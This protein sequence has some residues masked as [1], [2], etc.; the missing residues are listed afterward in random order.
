MIN[1]SDCGQKNDSKQI[2]YYWTNFFREYNYNPKFVFLMLL[3][4]W[5]QHHMWLLQL[6]FRPISNP[7]LWFN[8]VYG[9]TSKQAYNLR[10]RQSVQILSGGHPE[11]RSGIQRQHYRCVRDPCRAVL[12][13]SK[14]TPA[15][16]FRQRTVLNTSSSDD[17]L[18]V[19][20]W[21]MPASPVHL[22]KTF[23]YD[24][25][26]TYLEIITYFISLIIR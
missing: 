9:K 2:Q 14:S 18:C 19:P 16:S 1:D 23:K 10:S 15:H 25:N 26:L 20:D 11:M 12:R 3:F 4:F 13:C 21:L 22:L 8:M 5:L 24:Q 7:S 17:E 6:D